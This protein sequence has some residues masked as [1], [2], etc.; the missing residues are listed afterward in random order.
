MAAAAA[1]DRLL[2]AEPIA[3]TTLPV[4]DRLRLTLP[5]HG[6]VAIVG[7]SGS[8]KSTLLRR[9]AGLEPGAMPTP[10]TRSLANAGLGLVLLVLE[11]LGEILVVLG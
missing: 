7:S 1:L 10:G 9:L 11:L 3:S 2:G 4:L 5:A 8:G 6:L